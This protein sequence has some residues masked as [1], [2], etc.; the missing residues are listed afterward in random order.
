M[1]HR[2]FR[3]AQLGLVIAAAAVLSACPEAAPPKPVPAWAPPNW[4]H[5]TW[6]TAAS[7]LGSGTLRASRFNVQVNIQ[8]GGI[9]QSYD[10]AQLQES[11]TVSIDYEVGVDNRGR[12]YYLIAADAADGSSFGFIFE[13]VSE[14][15]L[16][17]YIGTWYNNY[18]QDLVGPFYL[19]KQ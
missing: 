17:G 13:R 8:T 18:L 12:R 19:T 2:I 3:T 1:K 14:N 10:F 15:E 7:D 16:D 4:M 11:G 9:T 5:G 6:K